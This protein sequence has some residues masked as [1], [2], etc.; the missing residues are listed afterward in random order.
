MSDSV[1][2]PKE[3][4]GSWKAFHENWCLGEPIALQAT[5]VALGL[6]TLSRI[7]PEEH[8]QSPNTGLAW[9]RFRG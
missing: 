3:F 8:G 4:G 6:S 7:W 5:D 9:R 1:Q 2:I